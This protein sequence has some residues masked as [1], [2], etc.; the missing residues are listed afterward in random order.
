LGLDHPH[1][2]HPIDDGALKRAAVIFAR[3]GGDDEAPARRAAWPSDLYGVPPKAFERHLVVGEPEACAAAL[4]QYVEPGARHVE[5]GPRRLIV[6]VAGTG[7]L[8]HFGLSRSAFMAR[9]HTTAAG[10]AG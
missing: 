9:S 4:G 2:P 3:T 10:M 5:A 6:M 1:R 7:A 8:Q